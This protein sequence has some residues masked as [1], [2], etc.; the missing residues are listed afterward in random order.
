MA[1][2]HSQTASKSLNVCSSNFSVSVTPLILYLCQLKSH[3]SLRLLRKA[4]FF[5]PGTKE[6]SPQ[7]QFQQLL[8]LRSNPFSRPFLSQDL[9]FSC[10]F[11]YLKQPSPTPD[12][13]GTSYLL[14]WLLIKKRICLKFNPLGLYLLMEN[15]TPS[16]ILLSLQVWLFL[17]SWGQGVGG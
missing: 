12:I 11:L 13:S 9:N 2:L 5:V 6:P 1:I 8:C 10:S 16:K 15:D 17:C 7:L 3:S 4:C 14:P